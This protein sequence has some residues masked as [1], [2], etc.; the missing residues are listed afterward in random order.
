MTTPVLNTVIAKNA[1]RTLT[2][3]KT[4]LKSY[5]KANIYMNVLSE[6]SVEIVADFQHIVSPGDI[7]N[8]YIDM[9]SAINSADK[10]GYISSIEVG[11]VSVGENFVQ[12]ILSGLRPGMP[13]VAEAF[14]PTISYEVKWKNIMKRK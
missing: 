10:E 2:A 6:T 13:V 14:F 7:Q 9:K 11:E 4:I 8:V 12:A 5:G 1:T 3:V